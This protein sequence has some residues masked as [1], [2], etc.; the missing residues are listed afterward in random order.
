MVKQRTEEWFKAREGRFT[1][2]EIHKLLGVKGIGQTGTTY[3]HEKAV[4]KM[5][6]RDKE[7][8]FTSA[9]MQRGITL[10]PVAFEIF[11][12]LKGMEFIEVKEA[13]FFPYGSDSGSSPDGLVG[14]DAVL[15]I[16]CPRP[17]KFFNLV[18]NGEKAIDKVYIAQMQHQMMCTNSKRCHFFNY[19]VYNNEP[20]YHEIV[21]ERD[22]VMIELMKDRIKTAVEVRDSHVEDLKTFYEGLANNG[23]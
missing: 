7:E 13:E 22:E 16:K 8:S 21:I 18:T 2:S 14:D 12:E 17:N 20:M 1:S 9:D 10:E 6:G 4:E 15:E 5:F 3:C 19:I 23:L 11:R